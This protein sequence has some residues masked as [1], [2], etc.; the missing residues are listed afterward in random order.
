MFSIEAATITVDE[1]SLASG[2]AGNRL[3]NFADNTY[4]CDIQ[5]L[6]LDPGGITVTIDGGH[7]G[8]TVALVIKDT[9]ALLDVVMLHCSAGGEDRYLA[10]VDDMPVQK[11]IAHKSGD[12]V[13]V[14][15]LVAAAQLVMS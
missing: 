8:A 15:L 6:A 3:I 10:V 14:T 7:F 1:A 5:E 2:V 12:L 4:P 13:G 9:V 11:F